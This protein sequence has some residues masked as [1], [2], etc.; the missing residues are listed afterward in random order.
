MSRP[1]YKVNE[2]RYKN[3]NLITF[4]D[5]A[6]SAVKAFESKDRPPDDADPFDLELAMSSIIALALDFPDEDDLLDMF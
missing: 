3:N 4:S 6:Y 2:E 1:L 5:H